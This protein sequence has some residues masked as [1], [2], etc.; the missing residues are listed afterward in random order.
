MR[1]KGD[2]MSE[3]EQCGRWETT[4]EA[5]KG[6]IRELRLALTSILLSIQAPGTSLDG[7]CLIAQ[8]ALDDSRRRLGTD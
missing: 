3:D 4:P 7:V 5:L 1:A 2:K 8:R 6:E